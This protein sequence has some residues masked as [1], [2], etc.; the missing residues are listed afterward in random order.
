ML[1]FVNILILT[2]D[3]T[4]YLSTQIVKENTKKETKILKINR[5]NVEEEDKSSIQLLCTIVLLML[6]LEKSSLS[7]TLSSLPARLLNHVLLTD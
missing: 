4:V 2:S 1:C 7:L 3:I 5:N 6:F